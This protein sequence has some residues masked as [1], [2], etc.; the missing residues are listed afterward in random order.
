M[1]G[2]H[3]LLF[4][5]INQL[6]L[7]TLQ[8]KSGSETEKYV[9]KKYR[10]RITQI[11]TDLTKTTKTTSSNM[12]NRDTYID[13]AKGL[14]MMLIICIHTEVFGV[15]GMPLTFIAVPMFSL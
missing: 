5:S 2:R 15:I 1:S 10:T 3:T 6:T 7:N 4:H 8:R 11:Y 13:I 14:C 12:N 9:T